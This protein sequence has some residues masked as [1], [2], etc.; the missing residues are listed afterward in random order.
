MSDLKVLTTEERDSWHALLPSNRRVFGS[1]EFATIVEKHLGYSAMLVAFGAGEESVMYPLFRRPLSELPFAKEAC[2]A[3][4]DSMTPEYTGPITR[5]AVGPSVADAFRRRFIDFCREERIVAEFAHLHPWEPSAELLVK[6]D[7]RTDREIV[8]VDLTATAEQ[9]WSESFSQACRKNIKRAM[10]EGVRI[11]QAS[12][13]HDIEKFQRIYLATMD[14]K[15]AMSKYYFPSSYFMDLFEQLPS[16][17][18]FV[19]AEY[20]EQIVAA[21]LYLHDDTDVYSYLGGADE[22]FQNL[23]PTNVV[24]YETIR[25]AQS[26]GKK[27]L[28][29]GGGYKPDDGILRFK[30][31]F[32]PL[33]ASFQVYRHIQLANEY[34]TLCRTWSAHYDRDLASSGE[35]FPAYRNIP[36]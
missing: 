21:T 36:N 1:V 33:R 17:V 11:Y 10:K 5:R 18:A 16:N 27:R 9:L 8:Y 6:E 4:W 13:S 28:I 32:S 34:D 30:A 25:W 20:N 29:L 2:V 24:I 31:S 26:L 12:G 3:G 15:G 7:V 19:L 23:R 14:R 22:K 35:Y